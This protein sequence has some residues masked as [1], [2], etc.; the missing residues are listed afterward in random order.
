[1]SVTVVEVKEC[2]NHIN[3]MKSKYHKRKVTRI[4]SEAKYLNEYSKLQWYKLYYVNGTKIADT[5]RFTDGKN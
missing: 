5:K 1:M 3:R 4:H 2:K